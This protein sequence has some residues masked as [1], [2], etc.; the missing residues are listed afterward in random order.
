MG[1]ER[2]ALDV[3][4]DG[5]ARKRRGPGSCSAPCLVEARKFEAILEKAAEIGCSDVVPVVS[6]RSLRTP[7]E[8]AERKLERWRRIAREAA[9]QCKSPLLTE[10]H[11]PRPLP[12]PS[13]GAAG[14][15]AGSSSAS[16]ADGRS[17]TSWPAAGGAPRSAVLLV[18]PTGRL[19]RRRGDGHPRGRLRGRVASAAASSSRRRPRWPGP[20]CLSITGTDKHVPP[21]SEGRQ[22]RDHPVAR[23]RRLRL[24][25]TWP[26]TPGSTSRWPSR[27][28]TSSRPSSTSSSRSRA[29]RPP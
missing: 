16:T 2:T 11:P 19:D 6:V 22:V 7:G 4:E 28:P 21:R 17:G 10:V 8:R 29:S 20:S 26:R 25:S 13:P 23:Q 14:R 1:E 18:G 15:S 12:G 5:G 3:A 9:K 24:A 27:S